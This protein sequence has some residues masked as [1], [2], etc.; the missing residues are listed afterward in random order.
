VPFS[1]RQL[2]G[3]SSRT[4]RWKWKKSGR[5]VWCVAPAGLIN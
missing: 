3:G 1:E 4:F 2:A 5:C